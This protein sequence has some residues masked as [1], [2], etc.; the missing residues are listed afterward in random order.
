MLWWEPYPIWRHQQSA[1]Q[2]YQ[3]FVKLLSPCKCTSLRACVCLLLVLGPCF[4]QVHLL[5][6]NFA[7]RIYALN[8]HLWPG[9]RL[10]IG[11]H[12]WM[13]YLGLCTLK[14]SFVHGLHV[15]YQSSWEVLSDCCQLTC[16]CAQDTCLRTPL[17][18][19]ILWNYW[20][21]RSLRCYIKLAH[22]GSSEWCLV[23]WGF[24]LWSLLRSVT[25]HES[26]L[27][28]DCYEGQERYY[29]K[30]GACFDYTY[31]LYSKQCYIKHGRSLL[32]FTLLPLF[33]HALYCSKI[34]QHLS[35][36]RQLCYYLHGLLLTLK[37]CN[38]GQCYQKE[39]DCTNCR[40]ACHFCIRTIKL[41]KWLIV[42]NI[43]SWSFGVR[44]WAS[45]RSI[46]YSRSP[47]CRHYRHRIVSRV[48][49]W[50]QGAL[51]KRNIRVKLDV[52]QVC[53]NWR[54]VKGKGR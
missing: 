14:I 2:S 24:L 1:G 5:W 7:I 29:F 18:Q 10:A 27:A 26:L 38:S 33:S 3:S 34:R 31:S 37:S 48:E 50:C 4:M 39:F 46:V 54:R 20:I 19:H 49:P 40:Q 12:F 28:A 13:A 36:I 16:S 8:V 53:P 11:K 52:V 41:A 51:N 42:V 32:L 43:I 23:G 21:W 44:C 22:A 25:Q 35:S 17:F 45:R 30:S 6:D 47:V 9:C 15:I